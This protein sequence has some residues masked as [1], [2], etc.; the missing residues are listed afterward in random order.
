MFLV[1]GSRGKGAAQGLNLRLD[2]IVR[3]IV[4]CKASRSKESLKVLTIAILV[5][6]KYTVLASNSDHNPASLDIRLRRRR[7]KT[8][9]EGE[10]LL[11]LGNL[12][13]RKRVS[14]QSYTLAI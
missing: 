8:Y 14:L 5:L 9:E 3:Y 12:L 1:E 4:D 10:G 11:E 13:F 2:E 7:R 6:L